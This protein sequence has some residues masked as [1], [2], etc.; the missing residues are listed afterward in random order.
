MVRGNVKNTAGDLMG[1]C[2]VFFD[3]GYPHH[4]ERIQV[5]KIPPERK[6]ALE[7][8]VTIEE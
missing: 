3:E 2:L 6:K 8:N 1:A 5:K 4:L 7:S